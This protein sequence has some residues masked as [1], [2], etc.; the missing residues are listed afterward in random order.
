MDNYEY[1]ELLKTLKTKLNNIRNVVQPE[2]IQSR[3]D[4]ITEL[5]N[6]QDF[7]NDA[8]H[9]AVIQKEKTQLERKLERFEIAQSTLDDASEMYEMSIDESDDESMELLFEE[10][11]ALE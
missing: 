5:E 1:T 8:A 9:A 2:A 3:L 7:W 11:P 10:A 6:L 4:E